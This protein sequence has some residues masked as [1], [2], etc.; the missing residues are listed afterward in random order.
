MGAVLPGGWG[1][2]WGVVVDSVGS[3]RP[4]AQSPH[5]ALTSGGVPSLRLRPLT[6]PGRPQSG[7][8]HH[9]YDEVVEAA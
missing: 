7:E 3:C 9:P 5:C 6:P 4:D 1:G 8:S 2:R